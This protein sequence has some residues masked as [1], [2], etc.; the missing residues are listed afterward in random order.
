L[1]ATVEMQG[2][3][4]RVGA[5]MRPRAPFGPAGSGWPT[6]LVLYGEE[7]ANLA[8]A[9]ELANDGYDVRRASD[10]A[11]LCERCAAGEAKLVIIGRPSRRGAGLD[12]L[13]E[14]RAERLAPKVEPS[15]RALWL[16][17]DG[18]LDDVLR[19]FD[20]GADDVLRAPFARAELLAR[21][22]ALL[23]RD[24]P[25]APSVIEYGALRI[26]TDAHVVT[27]AGRRVVGLRRLE[28]ALLLHLARDPSRV[29][30]KDELLH[31]VWGYRAPAA[32]ATVASHVSRVRRA[33][34]HVGADGWISVAWGF[35]YRLA[36]DSHGALA[37]P[38]A[39]R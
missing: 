18:E 26:D 33:L 20:A 28:Y 27:F 4:D 30:S 9:G 11:M 36:P 2:A 16:S 10:P 12:I 38:G 15:L 25:A 3:R 31:D 6:V 13:R 32:T 24:I 23:R 39:A 37:P 1:G 19:A 21:V 7:Y 5:V 22:R 35:G 14:L 17:A 29:H 34:A 8:L